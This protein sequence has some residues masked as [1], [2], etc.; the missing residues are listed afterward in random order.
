MSTYSQGASHQ[1][2]KM[3]MQRNSLESDKSTGMQMSPGTVPAEWAPSF[4]L[5]V[6]GEES[7]ERKTSSAS[8]IGGKHEE[9]H[10]WT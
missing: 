1:A 9:Q 2:L 6:K 7:R 4:V 8:F 5:Q 10:H 3:G